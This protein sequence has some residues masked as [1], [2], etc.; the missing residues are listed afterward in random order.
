MRTTLSVTLAT[1][2]ALLAVPVQAQPDPLT[3]ASTGMAQ[4][5]KPDGARK[6]C[7]SLAYYKRLNA[8]TFEN[9]AIT[10]IAP[11]GAVTLETVTPVTLKGAAVCGAIREQDVLA[12]K[13][14]AN[15]TLVPPEQATPALAQISQAL[16]SVIDKEICT[17][18]VTEGVV[19][20]AKASIDG[21]EQPALDQ[22]VIWVKESDGYTVAP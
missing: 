2:T 18:Y 12:G 5:Y 19:L 16:S 11:Q 6:T 3:P 15:G 10:L 22:A 13:L 21:V 17:R 20:K 1:V 9:R 7:S 8:T 4:C 14:R